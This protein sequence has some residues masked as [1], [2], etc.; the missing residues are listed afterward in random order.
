MDKRPTNLLHQ[1]PHQTAVTA[2]QPPTGGLG[3]FG[4]W[5]QQ[6]RT[7]RLLMAC[8]DR[9]LADIG[10][11]REDIPLVA[12]GQDPLQAP[13][14]TGWLANLRTRLDEALAARRQWRRESAEL[15]AYS[16]QELQDLGIKRRDIPAVLRGTIGPATA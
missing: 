4:T 6:R 2:A 11:A 12:R 5:L 14:R 8:S 3:A 9:V 10:I 16:D 7:E 1:P 15:M 13:E